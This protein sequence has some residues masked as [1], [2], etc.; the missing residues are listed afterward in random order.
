[1][2]IRN[3]LIC[4]WSAAIFVVLGVVGEPKRVCSNVIHGYTE[5]IELAIHASFDSEF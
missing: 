4:T 2:T 5:L 1:M 3:Q